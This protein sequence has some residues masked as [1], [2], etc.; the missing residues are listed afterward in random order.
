MTLIAEHDDIPAAGLG[1]VC[2][3]ELQ[4]LPGFCD[5]VI[6]ILRTNRLIQVYEWE[7]GQLHITERGRRWVHAQQES[8]S[9]TQ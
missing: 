7:P 5:V 6:N 9:L 4:W 8:I 1:A 3:R 2:V